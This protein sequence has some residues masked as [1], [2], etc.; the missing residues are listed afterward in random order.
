MHWAF[1]HVTQSHQKGQP[2]QT[3]GTIWIVC[4]E[5]ATKRQPASCK[6]AAA[7]I[8]PRLGLQVVTRYTSCTHMDRSPITIT[9][10]PYWPASTTYQKRPGDLDLLTLKVVS[11]SHATW[12]TSVPLLVFL[13]LSFL[14]LGRCTRQTDIR[15]KHRLMPPPI[16]LL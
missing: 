1:T 16:I 15:Q 2:A 14:Q 4:A 6:W 10:C 11:E 13:G 5:S 3:D 8:C 7:M 12:A 9:V